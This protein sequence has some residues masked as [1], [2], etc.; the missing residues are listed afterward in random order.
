MGINCYGEIA[1]FSDS[2]QSATRLILYQFSG[3][4]VPVV[5]ALEVVSHERWPGLV[6]RVLAV[7]SH[8]SVSGRYTVNMNGKTSNCSKKDHI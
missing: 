2:L 4:V 8:Q 1:K 7:V 6:G 5:I 3:V